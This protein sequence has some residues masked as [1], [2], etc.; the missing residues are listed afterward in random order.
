[1]TAPGADL[2]WG[3]MAPSGNQIF[4][5]ADTDTGID[6]TMQVDAGTA[7]EPGSLLLLSSG[8]LS[9]GCLVGKKVANLKLGDG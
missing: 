5:E 3:R 2:R 7:P 9:L 1:M 4:F 6:F 8:F